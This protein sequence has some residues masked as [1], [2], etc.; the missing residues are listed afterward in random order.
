[1]SAGSGLSQQNSIDV[2]DSRHSSEDSLP[3]MHHH[4]HA[5]FKEHQIMSPIK[6]I[7]S[8]NQQH[9]ISDHLHLDEV[10]GRLDN[11]LTAEEGSNADL[12][13]AES[14]ATRYSSQGSVKYSSKEKSEDHAK[15]RAHSSAS[16]INQPKMNE[17]EER[18]ASLSLLISHNK[19]HQ[20]QSHRLSPQQYL[21]R[22]RQGNAKSRTRPCSPKKYSK[23]LNKCDSLSKLNS[24][25]TMSSAAPQL[26]VSFPSTRY[27]TTIAIGRKSL[28]STGSSITTSTNVQLISA[29]SRR[30]QWKRY[31]P[32]SLDTGLTKKDRTKAI[33]EASSTPGINNND[34]SW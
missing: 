12:S 4:L 13:S 2:N 28:P 32:M 7:S 10:I 34:P 14:G 30:N 11:E 8:T 27:R 23:L 5:I 24:Y 18:R 33:L 26:P 6:E 15:E 29:T 22:C 3:M 1:M 9:N 16:L 17:L 20:D 31:R 19:Q 25:G 21:H